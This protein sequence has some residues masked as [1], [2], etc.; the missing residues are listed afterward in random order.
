MK[1]KTIRAVIALT[2]AM[3]GMGIWAGP[4]QPAGSAVARISPP[5]S[6]AYGKTLAEW[7]GEWL[8]WCWAGPYP[9]GGMVGHVQFLPWPDDV[10]LSGSGTPE[11]PAVFGGEM[12]FALRPGTPFVFH[13]PAWLRQRY[14]DGSIDPPMT[15]ALMLEDVRILFT[16]DGKPIIS[17]ENEAAFYI[18]ETPFDPILVSGPIA[19]LTYQG[20]CLV[21]PPLPPGKHAFHCRLSWII[22]AGAQPGMP[23]GMGAIL[24][25]SWTITVSPN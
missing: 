17:P 23:D 4:S 21:S 3:V 19:F 7:K 15:D 9:N 24:D 12:G 2:L 25:K 5:N 10:W 18:P 13:G 8:R 22:P 16:I 6:L 14:E 1:T 20:F 11:D